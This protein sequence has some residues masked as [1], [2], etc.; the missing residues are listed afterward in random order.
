MFVDNKSM[1]RGV[2]DKHRLQLQHAKPV[3]IWRGLAAI[4]RAVWSLGNRPHEADRKAQTSPPR[5]RSICMLSAQHEP[6]DK[7]V[8]HKEGISLAD[9]GFEVV[10]LCPDQVA[11]SKEVSGVRLITYTRPQGKIGRLRTLPRLL[12]MAWRIDADAYHCNEPDSW[13]VGVCLR[14]LRSKYV[15]F[16][17]HEHYPGQ[18]KRGLAWPLNNLAAWATEYYLQLLGLLTHRIVLAKYS[19]QDDF[20]WSR[21]RQV[22]VL[23]TTPLKSLESSPL[24]SAN[25]DGTANPFTFV[26]IGVIRRE[27]GSE[28]LLEAIHRLDRRGGGDFRVRIIGEFKDGSEAEFFARADRLSIRDRI[29][30]H[31][32]LPFDEAFSLVRQ[33]HAGLILFQKSLE[34]NVRGMPHKMFDYMLAGL[35]VIAPDFAPDIVGVLEPSNA[36]LLVDTSVPQCV[37]DAMQRLITDRELARQIGRCGRQAVFDQYNWEHDARQLV[38]TYH[39]L[40]G[41]TTDHGSMNT[42]NQK[43]A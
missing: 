2:M 12:A 37:A 25:E 36:G 16:D 31:R 11:A 41:I 20:S 28:Q 1:N 4:L 33:S 6:E 23:N 29:E 39:E 7:R 8:F 17:C 15:V 42:A 21:G 14:L 18:V 5:A 35:P 38:A 34:N 40:F 9:A 10:H 19:I 32:W 43:A 3:R 27:R 24:T 26:H 22:V 30:F 13:L